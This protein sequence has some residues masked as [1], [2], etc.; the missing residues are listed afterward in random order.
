MDEKLYE[1]PLG[2]KNWGLRFWIQLGREGY[3]YYVG[4]NQYKRIVNLETLEWWFI[5]RTRGK[6]EL[7]TRTGVTTILEIPET[8]APPGGACCVA[9]RYV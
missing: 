7:R 5:W 8:D 4:W 9:R 1:F 6:L 2:F 3:D